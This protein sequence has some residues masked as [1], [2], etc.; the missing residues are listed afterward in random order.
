MNKPRLCAA[1]NLD[2]DACPEI[3]QENAQEGNVNEQVNRFQ[4]YIVPG[5]KYIC[6]QAP[7]HV[8]PCEYEKSHGRQPHNQSLRNDVSMPC[9]KSHMHIL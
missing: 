1:S 9:E 4:L 6:G 3:V 7:Y 8:G 2:L 5:I